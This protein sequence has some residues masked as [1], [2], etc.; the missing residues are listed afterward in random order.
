[1]NNT[2]GGLPVINQDNGYAF[3]NARQ[4]ESVAFVFDNNGTLNINGT[5]INYIAVTSANFT[6]ILRWDGMMAGLTERDILGNDF[7][8]GTR[9][10][11]F[12]HRPIST[13]QYGNMQLLVNPSSVLGSAATFLFGW[14]AYGVIGQVSQGGSLPSGG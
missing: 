4:Y 1:L 8:R 5:D 2:A 10:L 12:R 7:P 3:V 9:Y 14:E 6:N 13:D 11:D